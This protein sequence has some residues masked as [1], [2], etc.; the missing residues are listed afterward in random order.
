MDGHCSNGLPPTVFSNSFFVLNHFLLIVV[1][2][3]AF[4]LE[5]HCVV[6]SATF[7]S[8]CCLKH[9]NFKGISLDMF[10]SHAQMLLR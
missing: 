6:Y 9:K 7:I 5:T 2:S 3:S 1:S 10:W 4:S 8:T